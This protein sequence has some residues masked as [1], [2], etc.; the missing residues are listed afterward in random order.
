[1]ERPCCSVFRSATHKFAVLA[2]AFSAGAKKFGVAAIAVQPGYDGIVRAMS[3]ELD[4]VEEWRAHGS[5]MASLLEIAARESYMFW[6]V[7]LSERRLR[8]VL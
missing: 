3:L 4:T 7:S 1:M 2:V 6:T 5:S 8:S